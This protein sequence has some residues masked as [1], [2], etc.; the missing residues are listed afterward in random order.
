MIVSLAALVRPIRVSWESVATGLCFGVV[1]VLA[2]WPRADG[3]L[4]RARGAVLL[5]FYAGYLAAILS[6]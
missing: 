4:G 6:A 2:T 3:W 1:T 5:A